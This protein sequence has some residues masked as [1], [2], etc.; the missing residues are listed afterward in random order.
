[1]GTGEFTTRILPLKDNLLRVVFRI[2]G[3]A[4]LSE[5]IVQETLLKVWSERSTW[6]VIEDMPA[7]CLMVARNLALRHEA[8]T[9]GKETEGYTVG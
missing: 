2:V 1:M 6:I 4:E 9:S 3:D 8:V 5:R 7:Y